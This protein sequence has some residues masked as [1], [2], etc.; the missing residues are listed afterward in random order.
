MIQIPSKDVDGPKEGESIH[1]S[2]SLKDSPTLSTCVVRPPPPFPNRLKGKN[3]Q[4]HFDSVRETFFQVK[5]NIPL[6]DV[7]QQMLPYAHF[8]K[9]L[10]TTQ[11]ATNVPKRAFLASNVSSIISNQVPIKCKDPGCPIVSIVIGHHNI[12]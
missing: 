10:Y 2:T 7:I 4:S 11:R 8:L 12:H 5:I 6:L 9:D 3:M 1:H